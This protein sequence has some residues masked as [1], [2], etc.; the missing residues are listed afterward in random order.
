ME[1]LRIFQIRI[2]KF[3]SRVLVL[4]WCTSVLK[5]DGSVII[6]VATTCFVKV[7]DNAVLG[8]AIHIQRHR[9]DLRMN[10][11]ACKLCK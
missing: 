10:Q 5:S 7:I 9:K 3:R 2:G 8:I 11:G 1:G 6:P 4:I